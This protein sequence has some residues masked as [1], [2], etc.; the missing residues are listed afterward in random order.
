MYDLVPEGCGSFYS[1]DIG[2]EVL[3]HLLARHRLTP[4][5]NGQFEMLEGDGQSFLGGDGGRGGPSKK[6]F[7]LGEDER[8]PHRAPCDHHTVT[9]GGFQHPYHILRSE[10]VSRTENRNGKDGL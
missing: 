4:C 5:G 8:I 6:G 2:T 3:S 9:A 7:Y 1:L 10:E